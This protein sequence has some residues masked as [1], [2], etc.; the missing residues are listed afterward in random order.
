MRAAT[1]INLGLNFKVRM[2]LVG[3]LVGAERQDPDKKCWHY[4]LIS[5]L[6]D[7]SKKA[8]PFYRT[9]WLVGFHFL[10]TD[11]RFLGWEYGDEPN[12]SGWLRHSGF[13]WWKFPTSYPPSCTH[14]WAFLVNAFQ[15]S[16]SQS[17][18]CSH[19]SLGCH[20]LS[21]ASALRNQGF[22]PRLPFL[23]GSC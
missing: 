20:C 18:L 19:G 21:Y 6:K 22:S 4:M 2:P 15:S 8:I 7:P 14:Y 1:D 16:S 12:R 9:S 3:T 11:K 13:S 17:D 23:E 5:Y 10:N